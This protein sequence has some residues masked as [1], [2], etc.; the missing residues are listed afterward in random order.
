MFLGLVESRPIAT[1]VLCLIPTAILIFIGAYSLEHV[2]NQVTQS[3]SR[4]AVQE[5]YVCDCINYN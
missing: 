5:Q 4:F 2:V 3:K 1:Y